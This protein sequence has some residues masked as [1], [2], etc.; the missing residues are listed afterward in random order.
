MGAWART[1]LAAT[2]AGMLAAGSAAAQTAPAADAAAV[3]QTFREAQTAAAG[4]D[5]VGISRLLSSDTLDRASQIRS[6]AAARGNGQIDTLDASGRFAAFGLRHYL[7]PDEI[8]RMDVPSLLRYGLDRGWLGGKLINSARLGQVEVDGDRAT[9]PLIVNGRRQLVPASF[10][11]E[12]GA[13]HIDMG[14][15]IMLADALLGAQIASSG[16]PEDQAINDLLGRAISRA[17]GIDPTN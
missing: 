10:V 7:A 11:K 16:Q 17:A 15:V 5:G 8:G 9:A 12:N 14:P 6:A 3:A 2:V 13:W 4:H 1:V